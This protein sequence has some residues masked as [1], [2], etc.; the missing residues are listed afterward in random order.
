MSITTDQINQFKNDG[1]VIVNDVFKNDPFLAIENSLKTLIDHEANKLFNK[2][3]I[4]STYENEDFVSQLALITKE[5]DPEHFREFISFLMSLD[6]RHARTRSMFEFCFN[7]SLLNVVEKLIGPE[8]TLNPSG[9]LRPYIPQRNNRQFLQ[10]PWHQDLIGLPKNTTPEI[11][12]AWI[13]F[14]DVSPENGCLQV[15]PNVTQLLPHDITDRYNNINAN[16]LPITPPIDCIMKK[17]DVLLINSLT[18][19]R[20]HS[21]QSQKVRW[22]MD[23]RFQKTETSSGEASDLVMIVRS[24][25]NPGAVEKNFHRWDQHWSIALSE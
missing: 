11:I 5:L 23:L 12:T 1:Y 2:G 6:F 18:P 14:V 21:N 9:H 25:H 8:I 16:Y 3:W 7:E 19:H 4:K 22:S 15:I 13:P 24:R 10:T 20:G 17:G